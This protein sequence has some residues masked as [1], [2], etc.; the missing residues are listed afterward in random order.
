LQMPKVNVET[1]KK[2][3]KRKSGSGS[4]ND[5]EELVEKPRNSKRKRKANKRDEDSEI[6]DY[7]SDDADY[8]PGS[9]PADD[10]LVEED[11]GDSDY[12][13]PKKSKHLGGKKRE[14][15]KWGSKCYRSNPEHRK[16][17]SHPD[18]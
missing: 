8:I 4:E 15:C 12:S 1:T 18:E 10:D 3:S 7:L 5:W 17:F 16:E 6:D 13:Q 9:E 2:K 14:A 11:S